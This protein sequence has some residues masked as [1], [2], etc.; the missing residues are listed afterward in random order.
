MVDD[1]TCSCISN[2]SYVWRWCT[3]L[4]GHS[5]VTAFTTLTCQCYQKSS[6]NRRRVCWRESCVP[7]KW[8]IHD[9]HQRSNVICT[10][11]FLSEPSLFISQSGYVC[12]LSKIILFSIFPAVDG[13]MNPLLLMQFFTFPFFESLIK[14][15]SF[16][17]S[18]ISFVSQS[19]PNSPCS[20]M[21]DVL[22]PT[23]MARHLVLLPLLSSNAWLV[24]Y[25]CSIFNLQ[26][27]F[28]RIY[29]RRFVWWR[30]V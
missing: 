11:P 28:G 20:I 26:K 13:S 21:V 7:F 16:Q 15:P 23:L 22:W 5:A 27:G 1:S 19:F 25:G 2:R 8:L 12:S 18:G 4:S 17:S 29:V 6:H 24:L 3:S 9:I 10:R 30:C 14:Y